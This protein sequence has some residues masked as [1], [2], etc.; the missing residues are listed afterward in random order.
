MRYFK[1]IIKGIVQG[2]GFRPFLFNLTKSLNLNG[3]ILNKGNIGVELIISCLGQTSELEIENFIFQIKSKKPPISY[4]ESITY[5]EINEN[6]IKEEYSIPISLINNDLKIL[7]SIEKYGHELALPPDIAICDDCIKEMNDIKFTRFYKYPFIACAYCGPRFTTVFALPYDR[8]RTTM[9]AFPYCSSKSQHSIE[10]EGSCEEDYHDFTNRRFHAETFACRKCGPNYFLIVNSNFISNQDYNKIKS[11]IDLD[12]NLD[13][14]NLRVENLDLYLSSNDVITKNAD[15]CIRLAAELIKNGY[16]LAVMGIGG[17]HLV[18]KA[19]EKSVIEKLRL[20]KKGRRYKPFAIMVRNRE[21]IKNFVYINKYEEELLTSFRRPIILLD[22]KTPFELPENIAP[23]LPNIGIML[24][25]AGIHY[26]LFEYIGDIP[27][28]F[29]SG[30]ISNLPM[31]ITPKDVIEQLNTLADA[32]LLHNRIIYQRCDDSVLRVHC[33]HSNNVFTYYEKIIRRS[34]GYV[35]EYIPL[36]FKTE[37]KG[38]IAVGAELNSTAAISIGNRIFPTQYIGNV[39]N[40]ETYEF[41]K[42]S[43][44][45]MKL[46]L[47]INDDEIQII[48]HDFHPLFQ[49]TKLAY[50]LKEK[51]EKMVNHN[52]HTQLKKDNREILL[53]P[54]QHHFAH[55]ASLLIDA[56]IPEDTPVVIATLDG[57]GY[58][59]DG[60]I[61]GGEIISGTYS[62]LKREAH[63]SYIPMIGGD[64]CAK[65]PAR[66]LIGFLLTLYDI[67]ETKKLAKLLNITK[68]LEFG[69]LEFNIILNMFKNNENTTYTSSCGRLLDSISSLLDICHL[70]TYEGE[71]AMKLEGAAYHGDI[72]AFDFHSDIIY[73]IY[74]KNFQEIIPTERIIY[75]IIKVL[76]T[77][78]DGFSIPIS[79]KL[80]SDLAASSLNSLGKIIA[81]AAI[82]IAIKNNIKYIGLSGGVGYN[83]IISNSFYTEIENSE[84]N[85]ITIHHKNIP[86]GDAGICIGQIVIAI[87]KYNNHYLK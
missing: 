10:N 6:I 86:C 21:S 36:P 12:Y 34:R 66:M 50:E 60:N 78:T 5:S 7:P 17:V 58:G 32:F 84:N 67:E 40:L 71:P 85:I 70:R 22:K 13:Y 8:I 46:L 53:I 79:D 87:S 42:N 57:V 68:N 73:Y 29:T 20:R 39:Y 25:Y 48:V 18:A 51:F 33:Y 77:K 64:K 72:N 4:I 55:A 59:L 83:S 54:I 9:N 80:R 75:N 76:K 52:E 3:V 1:I 28:I 26:L 27:L 45:H 63:L 56:S 37:L 16:I 44:L 47:Q 35:P 30:N 2:V 14:N 81:H 74:S 69:D 11:I 65:F 49:S 43:I 38:V 15:F 31:A 61:W 24:P 19:T 62:N 82:K 23:G 41:L